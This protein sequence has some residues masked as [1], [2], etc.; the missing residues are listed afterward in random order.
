MSNT[1]FQQGQKVRGT[2]PTWMERARKLADGTKCVADGVPAPVDAP[3][4]RVRSVRTVT[5]A[6]PTAAPH[7][8]DGGKWM[9]RAFKDAGKKGHDLH[10]TLGV[11]KGQKIPAAKL[12]AAK[13]SPNLHTRRMANLAANVR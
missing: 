6:E 3:K 2:A 5:V 4:Y 10:A 8:A 11:H 7:M 13:N 1:T 12:S 9:E